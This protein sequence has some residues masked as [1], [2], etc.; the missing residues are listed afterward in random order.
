MGLR[1]GMT[2][3]LALLCLA[4]SAW[5]APRLNIKIESGEIAGVAQA[6]VPMPVLVYIYGG[7]FNEGS[8]SVPLYDGAALA[9]KGIIVVTVSYRVGVFG[10]MAHSELTRE[11]PKH[12]SG[13]YGLLDQ[14]A[15]LRWV[16]DNIRA[17]DGDPGR[18][19]VFGQSAG[20]MSVYLMT[21][22]PL[23]KGL[24]QRAIVQS[25]PGALRAGD[26]LAGTS[27]IWSL[28]LRR[29]AV[30]IRQPEIVEQAVDRCGSEARERG[31][32]VLGKFRVAGGSERELVGV[33][34]VATLQARVTNV[35]GVGRNG[36]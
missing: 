14:V 24:F 31:V 35:H 27:G 4:G 18:V 21:A 16:H 5:G 1:E 12:S 15:A 20:A 22:S 3:V 17:F 26:S 19:T 30:R 23:A 13:N 8:I 6:R 25:G 34:H 9:R 32:V 28:P 10:F 33:T 29:A 7:G 36:R 2:L 11:S